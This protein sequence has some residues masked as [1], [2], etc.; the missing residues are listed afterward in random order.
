MSKLI[1]YITIGLF[2]YLF[3]SCSSKS[4]YEYWPIEKFNIVPS[5]LKSNEEIKVIYSSGAPDFTR[6]YY[7]HLI[8]VSEESGDTVNVLVIGDRGFKKEDGKK[9]FNYF[10]SDDISTKVTQMYLDSIEIDHV[11]QVEQ[12]DLKEF[13]EVARDPAF[14]YIADNNYPT[15]IGSIGILDFIK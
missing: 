12:Y 9:V 4:S 7:C 14:D 5:A 2:T 13:S 8:V 6:E 1:S 15:V 3:I 10:D 11:D